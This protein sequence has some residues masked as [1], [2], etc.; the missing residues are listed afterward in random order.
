MAGNR[1][2]SEL[3]LERDERLCRFSSVTDAVG[4][5]S[6]PSV[7]GAPSFV[8]NSE[9]CSEYLPHAAWE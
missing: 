7:I 5:L 8:V 3:D 1:C 2:A 9:R 4:L 6:W